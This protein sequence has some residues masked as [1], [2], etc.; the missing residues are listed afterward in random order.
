MYVY[1]VL[2]KSVKKIV[3]SYKEHTSTQQFLY[4]QIFFKL[5]VISQSFYNFYKVFLK[6]KKF[7]NCIKYFTAI[8]IISVETPCCDEHAIEKSK[9]LIILTC[10]LL[11]V[12]EYLINLSILKLYLFQLK[13]CIFMLFIC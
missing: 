2:C 11:Y 10:I 12:V 5:M 13:F 9:I 6:K 3:D 1:Q 7:L 8:T 4:K